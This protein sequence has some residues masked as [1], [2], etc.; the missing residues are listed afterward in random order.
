VRSFL[1]GLFGLLVPGAGH[2]YTGRRRAALLFLLP[3]IAL[4]GA[5]VILFLLSGRT[6]LIGFLLTPGVLPGLAAVNV[7]LAAWR[8]AAGVDA[9]RRLRPS[10]VTIGA[11]A[12]AIVALVLVPHLLVGRVVLSANDFIDSMFATLETP[13]ATESFSTEP[14]AFPSEAITGYEDPLEDWIA[15]QRFLHPIPTE[16]GATPG[17]RRPMTSGTGSLPA[18]GAAVPW[19]RA[20]ATP[21]GDDGRF[22]LLLLG[23]DAGQGR[24]SRRM[25]VML[26]VEIDVATGK[27]AMIGLPRNLINAP[28]PPGPARDAVAC[29][30][31]TGLLNEAYVEATFRHPSR[32]PGTGA[33][34]GIGAVRSVVMQLT[35][36]PVDGVLVADLWGVIKV[37]DAMGG[38]DINIPAPVH[39]YRYPDPVYGN[40]VLNIPKGQQH[41][42]GRM[43]LAYARSRH[44]DSDYGRMGR[45]QTFLLA[46]RK[47]IG[48]ATVFNAPALFDAAKG[49]TWTD[50][51]RDALPALGDLFD[52]ASHAAVKQLR[53][54]PPN[55]SGYLTKGEII[56]IQA[57]IAA[58]LGV[59]PPPPP[60]PTPS[61]SPTSVP[62]DTPPP[63]S[64]S[65]T[66]SASPSASSSPP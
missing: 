49:F 10:R 38:L 56:R 40:I 6:S 42:D 48:P 17:P 29:G 11:L 65:P 24:W 46:L 43:A 39:D 35:G 55:Y 44:Q 34:K 32:W 50:L 60:P 20:G 8:I 4:A 5:W 22:D 28:F 57:D 12:M 21:W 47:Q 23:S 66:E 54:T 30:C 33:V 3:V 58:L 53:I 59:A 16:P 1:A 52:K 64:P 41:L 13:S 26:L 27:V 25:D 19:T 45:Q 2:A 15:R 7:V 62:T 9:A 18:L 51:P 14:S 63:P 37:V 36:R 61:P 31:L